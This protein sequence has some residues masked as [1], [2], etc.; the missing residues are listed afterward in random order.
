MKKL[1]LVL[2]TLVSMTSMAVSANTASKA[3]S[4]VA[5]INTATLEQLQL[6][7]GIG[8]S[9]ASAIV[10]ER[11][12][13]PFDSA[14][15]LLEVKGIGDKVLSQITPYVTTKGDTTLHVVD[16]PNKTQ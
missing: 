11:K 9:K 5:N 8:L 15:D 12:L 1:I 7:P 2:L 13:K 6:I 14:Q 10:E 4:G 3:V 16:S